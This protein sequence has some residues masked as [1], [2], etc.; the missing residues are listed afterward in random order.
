MLIKIPWIDKIEIELFF[1]GEDGSQGVL[2]FS[3]GYLHRVFCIKDVTCY[4]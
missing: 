4:V 1:S 2:L 3:T